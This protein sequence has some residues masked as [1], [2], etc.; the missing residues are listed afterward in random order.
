MH[1]YLYYVTS[2]LKTEFIYSA[3]YKKPNLSAY[4]YMKEFLYEKVPE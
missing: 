1:R 3:S 2:V 4:F